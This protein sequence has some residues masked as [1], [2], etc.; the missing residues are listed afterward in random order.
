MGWPVSPLEKIKIW[1]MSIRQ[2][3]K[4]AQQDKPAVLADMQ[5]FIIL[6]IYVNI[7]NLIRC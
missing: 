1:L 2:A 4:R 5:F 6:F 3:G 7:S